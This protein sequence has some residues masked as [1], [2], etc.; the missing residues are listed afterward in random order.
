MAKIMPLTTSGRIS[1]MLNRMPRSIR[2]A[3]RLHAVHQFSGVRFLPTARKSLKQHL[4]G[5]RVMVL[6]LT[7]PVTRC[8]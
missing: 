8:K 7:A 2:S 5:N 6:A 4:E 1:N 3:N